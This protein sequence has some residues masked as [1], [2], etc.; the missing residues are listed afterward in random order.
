MTTGELAPGLVAVDAVT[1]DPRVRATWRREVRLLLLTVLGMSLGAAMLLVRAH[2]RGRFAVTAALG[3][4]TLLVAIGFAVWTLAR[5]SGVGDIRI[6]RVGR[7]PKGVWGS[8]IPQFPCLPSGWV[9]VD[10]KN[11]SV[12]LTYGKHRIP[13]SSAGRSVVVLVRSGRARAVMILE[14][15]LDSGPAVISSG[16]LRLRGVV[17]DT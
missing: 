7:P 8:A 16:R 12:S 3:C 13:V 4:L 5:P 1:G 17:G 14:V 11:R 6:C 15:G 10:S 9:V 2:H